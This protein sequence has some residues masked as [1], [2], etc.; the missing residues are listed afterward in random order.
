M[1]Q[2]KTDYPFP[3]HSWSISEMNRGIFFS[4]HVIVTQGR[5]DMSKRGDT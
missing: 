5:G 2:K 1:L 4:S 3:G